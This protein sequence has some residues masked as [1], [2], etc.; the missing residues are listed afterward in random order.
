MRKSLEEKL[1][2]R[3]PDLKNL[4]TAAELRHYLAHLDQLP[5]ANDVRLALAT[6]L[7]DHERPQEA[8]IELLQSLASKEQPSQSA[9]AELLAKLSAKSGKRSDRP[10][11]A[12]R[13]DMSMLNSRHRP[14][15]RNL[16]WESCQIRG[17]PDLPAA[18]HRAGLLAASLANELVHL[19]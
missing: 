1:S 11:R 15:R 13:A 16:V 19:E 12:G 10:A 14:L 9:A 2:S 17:N 6:Y 7:I 4:R 18:A 5:G 3:R 8:E